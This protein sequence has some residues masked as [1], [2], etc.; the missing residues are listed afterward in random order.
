VTVEAVVTFDLLDDKEHLPRSPPDPPY[1][2]QTNDEQHGQASNSRGLFL[3]TENGQ[4]ELEMI[5]NPKR[6]MDNG[7]QYQRPTTPA[8][9]EIKFVVR[10]C[11]IQQ[12]QDGR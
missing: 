11:R 9:K 5:A 3:L 8:V 1:A 12:E 10:R 6:P 7:R 2:T 4:S